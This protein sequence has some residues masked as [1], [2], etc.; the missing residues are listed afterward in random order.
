MLESAR[1]VGALFCLIVTV[2]CLSNESAG[3]PPSVARMQI[4][5]ELFV[6]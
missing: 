5:Y 1:S 6:A 3:E 2:S 4:V